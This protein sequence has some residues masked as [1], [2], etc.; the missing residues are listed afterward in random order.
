MQKEA[1]KSKTGRT[2]ENSRQINSSQGRDRLSPRKI[3]RSFIIRKTLWLR[4]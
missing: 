3:A 1:V 2:E 4:V